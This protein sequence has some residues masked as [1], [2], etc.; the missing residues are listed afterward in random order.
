MKHPWQEIALSDYENHMSLDSV[1]QLQGMNAMM[2]DQLA[3]GTGGAV[4]ILGV[5]GGNGL[6]HIRK[7]KWRRVYGVDINAEYLRE[8]A[9]RH[10]ELE[11]VLECLQVDL[12]QEGRA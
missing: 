12:A 2:R 5:A 9:R 8:T 1:L 4:M 7:D 6:E 10:P 11:G 3:F